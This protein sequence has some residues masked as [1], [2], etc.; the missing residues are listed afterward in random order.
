MYSNYYSR[1]SNI[2]LYLIVKYVIKL[3]LDSYKKCQIIRNK[4]VDNTGLQGFVVA[5]LGVVCEV[6]FR[7]ESEILEVKYLKNV[8]CCYI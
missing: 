7:D 8:V 3:V 6:I 4:Q 2:I 1:S 5:L